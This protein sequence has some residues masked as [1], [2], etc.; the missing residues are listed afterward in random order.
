MDLLHIIT[1]STMLWEQSDAKS[2]TQKPST[3]NRPQVLWLLSAARDEVQC[4]CNLHLAQNIWFMI[5][6]LPHCTCSLCANTLCPDLELPLHLPPPQALVLT[7]F[8]GNTTGFIRKIAIK[9]GW[10][11]QPCY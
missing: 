6:S 1:I 2:A 7:K 9:P 10:L 3:T 8:L 5:L 11:L 4:L